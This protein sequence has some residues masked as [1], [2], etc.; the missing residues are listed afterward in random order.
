MGVLRLA[1]ELPHYTLSDYLQW[2][3]R[4]E[5][6]HGVPW[7]MSPAPTIEHQQISARIHAQLFNELSDCT[8]CQALL[9]VDWR[10]D[11]ETVVQPDNLVV[12]GEVSGS[13]LS[14]APQ[15]IFEVLSPSTAKKDQ[16]VKFELYQREGV[17]WY[18]V[19]DPVSQVVKLYRLTD[20]GRLVK[21]ADLH[22]ERVAIDLVQCRI[23]F[24]AAAIWPDS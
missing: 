4:W 19:V 14:R 10:I 3:G 8:A 5:L 6:I 9:P 18:G 21:H 1:D 11:D 16:G 17:R 2:E 24:D 20:D 12:C 15:L 22:D 7:A 13:W 23:D